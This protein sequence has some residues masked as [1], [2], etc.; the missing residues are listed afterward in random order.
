HLPCSKVMF[1]V[2]N[3]LLEEMELPGLR[4]QFQEITTDTSKFELTVV[5]Q[6]TRQG[7]VLRAQYSTTLFEAETIDRL[8]RYFETLLEGIV[9]TP[10]QRLSQLPLLTMA[11]R[12]Q[13]LVEWNR[14]QTSYPVDQC[15]HRVFE[16]R[17][18]ETPEATALIFGEYQLTYQELNTRANQL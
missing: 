11:E 2:Q 8:L 4:L 7:L 6:E 15:V 1:L 10:A 12:H 5:A 17:A 9:A 16:A 3:Q 14:T 13:L 18:T